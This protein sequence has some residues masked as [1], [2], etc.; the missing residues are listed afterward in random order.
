MNFTIDKKFHKNYLDWIESLGVSY[1]EFG[2][3]VTAEIAK[4]PH[5]QRAFLDT[6]N[7]RIPGK[8]TPEQFDVLA[9]PLSRAVQQAKI[10]SL[11]RQAQKRKSP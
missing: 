9:P 4:L 8:L 2:E 11:E 3:L 6:V 5:D 10:Q 7:W 1:E